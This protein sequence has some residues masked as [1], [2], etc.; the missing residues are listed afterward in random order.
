MKQHNSDRS[1][2]IQSRLGPVMLEGRRMLRTS[3]RRASV[4]AGQVARKG[5]RIVGRTVHQTELITKRSPWVSLGAAACTGL[6][7]GAI[8]TWLFRRD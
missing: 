3:A 2:Q 4:V 5:R 7:L 6:F 8:A 1:S